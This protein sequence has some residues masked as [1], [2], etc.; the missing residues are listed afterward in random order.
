MAQVSSKL[1]CKLPRF[2]EYGTVE[3]G[4]IYNKLKNL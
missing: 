2:A 3:F 1:Q 4:R